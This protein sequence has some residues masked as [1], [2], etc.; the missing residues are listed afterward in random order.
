VREANFDDQPPAII[1]EM[2]AGHCRGTLVA[3]HD[4]MHQNPQTFA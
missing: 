4:R 2:P 1:A 3:Y